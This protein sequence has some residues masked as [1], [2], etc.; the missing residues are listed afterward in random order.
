MAGTSADK[1]SYLRET[2]RLIRFALL[3][4]GVDVPESTPF[5]QY[6]G[7]VGEIQS[8]GQGGG[9]DTQDCT[10]YVHNLHMED[11]SLYYN[12]GESISLPTTQFETIEHVNL[13]H[14]IYAEDDRFGSQLPLTFSY[15]NSNGYFSIIIYPV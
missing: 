10:L 12:N 6:A 9:L 7:K 2:K 13:A 11:A 15:D 3:T 1:L 4:K 14:D 5:R 8:G